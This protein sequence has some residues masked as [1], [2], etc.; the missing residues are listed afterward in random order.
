MTSHKS[1]TTV[2]AAAILLTLAS[3]ATGGDPVGTG[4]CCVNLDLASGNC[5]PADEA[6]C[7]ASGGAYVGDFTVCS[8]VEACFF[9]DPGCDQVT[10]LT[11]VDIDAVC[12][13]FFGG[14]FG[15]PGEF[16][17]SSTI[18]VGLDIMPGS[19]PNPIN[20]GSQGVVP[21]LLVGDTD[22][23]VTQVDIG[24]LQISRA[25]GVGVSVAPQEGPP[26]PRTTVE[27][28]ATPFTGELCDCHDL[29]SD[30]IDDLVLKFKN[31]DLVNRLELDLEPREAIVTLVLSGTLVDG[32]SFV[33]SDC[34]QI[35]PRN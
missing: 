12:C 31:S 35:I 29:G 33:A 34:V 27:D 30:G 1:I 7:I 8:G 21:M 28:E 2:L 20:P 14:S 10:D 6:T 4:A 32:T 22:F 23:D 18:E 15:E 5:T 11:C 26:G 16:C 13:T 25:D 17:P 19:C 24:S 9:I 3:S